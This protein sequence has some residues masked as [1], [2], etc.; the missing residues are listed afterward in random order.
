M[1]ERWP[2]ER[3]IFLFVSHTLERLLLERAAVRRNNMISKTRYRLER[4]TSSKKGRKII[5][6]WFKTLSFRGNCYSECN[7]VMFSVPLTASGLESESR[8]SYFSHCGQF[9]ED[10]L[11]ARPR[12][13]TLL[14]HA[15]SHQNLICTAGSMVFSHVKWMCFTQQELI[16]QGNDQQRLKF[17]LSKTEK[18]ALLI[19]HYN[20]KELLQS[21]K[22]HFINKCFS[23]QNILTIKVLVTKIGLINT[24]RKLEK[25][26]VSITFYRKIGNNEGKGKRKI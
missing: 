3:F 13:F 6:T 1:A 20:L 26:S 10:S 7:E 19:L 17:I 18:W 22:M 9:M 24:Q 2:C 16:I 4:N 21:W 15:Y 23:P 14:C 11:P 25:H 12:M 8:M 5:F